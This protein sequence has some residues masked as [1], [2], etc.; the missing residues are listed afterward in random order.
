MSV[1]RDRNGPIFSVGSGR[2]DFHPFNTCREDNGD[3]LYQ[4]G[5]KICSIAD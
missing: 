4:D 3:A 1:I 2:N 5:Q